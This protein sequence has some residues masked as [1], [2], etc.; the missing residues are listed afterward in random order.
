MI[1]SI[2][3]PKKTVNSVMN[4][5]T[6]A[7]ADLRQVATEQV[8]EAEAQG[9]VIAQAQ[10][11]REAALAEANRAIAVASKL[12]AIVGEDEDAATVV[13]PLAA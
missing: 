9:V 8:D 5:F 6:T 11:A 1:N 4:V 3:N 10:A 13:L 7:I 2:F 12:S